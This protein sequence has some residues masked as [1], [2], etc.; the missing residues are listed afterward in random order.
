LKDQRL[1]PALGFLAP[2][3]RA[4]EGR[5]DPATSVSKTDP[6]SGGQQSDPRSDRPDPLEPA[7]R[8]FADFVFAI[9]RF[10]A[11]AAAPGARW[12]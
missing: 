9:F 11:T 3:P 1:I 7:G 6:H 4:C 8:R 10:G 5:T 2:N 12:I